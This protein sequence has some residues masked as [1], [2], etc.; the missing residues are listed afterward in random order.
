MFHKGKHSKKKT[1]LIS[2]AARGKKDISA[3]DAKRRL[4]WD[5]AQEQ[6][7]SG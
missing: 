2:V 1:K 7:T 6:V 4:L 3:I 5:R